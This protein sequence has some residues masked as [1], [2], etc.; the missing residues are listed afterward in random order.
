VRIIGGRY[1][2]TLIGFDPEEGI[3]PTPDRVRETLFNWLDR[4]LPGARCL[5]LFA[6]SGALG[7]EAASRGAATVLMLERNPRVAE[8]LRREA[9]RLAGAEVRV[10]C[11]DAAAWLAAPGV[12]RPAPFDVVFLDPPYGSGLVPVVAG[13]L[14]TGGWLG[15][16]ALV[17][18]ETGRR[19]EL[20]LPVGWELT[21]EKRAGRV[22]YHLAERGGSKDGVPPAGP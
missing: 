20:A 15:E 3:R 12:R 6:G 7:L 19:E 17:Y 18:I 8:R 16:G 9:A 10:E 14:E 5:D 22:R 1:R 11:A 2:R 13:A 21:R 4:D